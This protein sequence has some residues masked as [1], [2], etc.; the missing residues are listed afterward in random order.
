MK[1]R[2]LFFMIGYFTFLSSAYS[3]NSSQSAWSPTSAIF[4]EL[5]GNGGIASLNYDRRFS[6]K[7]NGIGGRIG[8]GIG[9]GRLGHIFPELV[10]TIPLAINYLTGEGAHHLELGAGI[11][12]ATSELNRDPKS[13]FFVPSVG[14]RLQSPV[15]RFS[16]R[17]FVSP[18]IASKVNVSGGLSFGTSF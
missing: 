15:R 7:H 5:A 9:E 10:P 3:Q 8:I 16:F 4:L 13:V 18:F 17:A 2:F 11:T 1:Q 14:Y 6:G 12:I